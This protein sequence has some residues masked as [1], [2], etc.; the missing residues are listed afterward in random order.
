MRT[1]DKLG[2]KLTKNHFD[3]IIY[4]SHKNTAAEA[5]HGYKVKLVNL[6]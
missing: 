1:M 4:L 2:Q 5:N 6:A 3:E